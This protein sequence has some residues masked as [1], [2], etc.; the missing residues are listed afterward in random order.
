MPC[1]LTG[2]W[3]FGGEG[4]DLLCRPVA[5]NRFCPP[6][7][8]FQALKQCGVMSKIPLFSA[9]MFW[10]DGVLGWEERDE[11]QSADTERSLS[12]A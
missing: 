7:L 1:L 10:S 4:T 11:Q 3:A 8:P 2:N 9:G 6:V 5:L 12:T